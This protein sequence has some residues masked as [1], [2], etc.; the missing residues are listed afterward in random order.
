MAPGRMDR[1]ATGL[2]DP[3]IGSEW[4]TGEGVGVSLWR[5]AFLKGTVV[6]AQL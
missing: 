6:P 4:A 1:G 2:K 3:Q 5:L